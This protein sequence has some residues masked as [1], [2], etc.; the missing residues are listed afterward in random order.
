MAEGCALANVPLLGGETAEHPGVMPPD[1]IDLAGAALGVVERDGRIDGSS[2][3]P[4]DV[5][6]GVASPNLRSNGF[7]LVRAIIGERD[8]AEPFPGGD[9]TWGEVLV[10]PAVIYSAAVLDAVRSGG[11]HGLAH[12]TGGG[13]AGNL[14]RVLPVGN[15]AVIHQGTWEVPTVFHLLQRMGS[16]P[17]DEMRMAFN[18]GLGFLAVVA[19][20]G[21]DRIRDSFAQSGHTTWAVGEMTR[22]E[23]GASRSA[24]ELL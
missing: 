5:V 7:S 19:P 22:G 1:Q 14:G 2:I 11:V 21:V 12:V 3:R 15:R 9:R 18:L 8:L 24:R 4:G 17:D 10:E 6:I 16:I 23:I 13:I 20:T